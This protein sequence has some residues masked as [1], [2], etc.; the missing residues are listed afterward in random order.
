M[1][2][3][4]VERSKK[5]RG[6]LGLSAH[7]TLYSSWR[8][9]RGYDLGISVPDR[10]WGA[11][12]ESFPTDSGGASVRLCRST[13]TLSHREFDLYWE[14]AAWNYDYYTK[15]LTSI[16]NRRDEYRKRFGWEVQKYSPDTI[17]NRYFLVHHSGI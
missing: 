14:P 12:K 10:W 4:H 5:W 8:R 15:T 13:P 7:L 9:S 2:P 3:F 6:L 1:S 16:E 11:V 17:N